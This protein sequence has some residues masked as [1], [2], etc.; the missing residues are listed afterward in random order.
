MYRA[1]Q[2]SGRSLLQWSC[3]AVV[4]F[5]TSTVALPQSGIRGWGEYHLTT[6]GTTRLSFRLLL[7]RDTP[8]ASPGRIDRRMGK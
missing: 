7:A 2:S 1:V 4:A 5:V 3:V 6:D 8:C